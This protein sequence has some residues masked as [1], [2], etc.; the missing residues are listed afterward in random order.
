[1]NAS[2]LAAHVVWT[3]G[4]L[5]IASSTS[6]FGHSAREVLLEL[7]LVDANVVLPRDAFGEGRAGG[8]AGVGAY[9]GVGLC[10]LGRHSSDIS[11]KRG[12]AVVLWELQQQLVP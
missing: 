4:G 1:M 6:L 7:L 9:G 8:R 10:R 5:G 12:H 2:I 3:Q 11:G